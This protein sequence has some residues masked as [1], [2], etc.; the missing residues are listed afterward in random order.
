MWMADLSKTA[1][2]AALI[3]HAQDISSLTIK[4][5]FARES[6]R[7]DWG[8]IDAA[9][10]RFD[11]T[12]QSLGRSTRDLLVD[13]AKAAD[14]EGRRSQMLAGEALNS[15]ENRPAL[16]MALRADKDA[17]HE[18]KS[19]RK[20]LL[21]FVKDI[22]QGRVL[23]SAG[24]PFKT[25][26]NIGIGGS[27]LGPR[28]A[29]AALHPYWHKGITPRFVANVDGTE[30]TQVL[31]EVVPQE[32]LFIVASKSFGTQETLHNAR[33]AMKWLERELPEG[34]DIG[35]HF[36]GVT[37]NADAAEGFGIS[38]DRIFPIWDWVGGR[39]SVWSSVG[40]SLAL[41][42]GADHFKEFLSGAAQMDHHFCTA[43][44]EQNMPIL[45]GLV[46]V[47]NRNFLGNSSHAI[48]PY[49]QSLALLPSYLQQL[50]MESNGK[51][52]KRDGAPVDCSTAPAI[53]GAAGT[54]G[55]H[56][57]YQ[58]LHQ[59]TD[60]ASCDILLPLRPHHALR[61]H[62]DILVSHAIAQADGL[63]FGRDEAATRAE[64]ASE[65]LSEGEIAAMAPHR[66]FPGNRP[67]SILTM[68]RLTPATLGAMLALYEHKVFTQG[69][70]WN[71]NSF[72]QWGV[73]LGKS[74]AGTV[75]DALLGD[76][77]PEGVNP[78][79]QKL[80]EAARAARSS[81][82]SES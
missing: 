20:R 78:S 48:L 69:V 75:L 45:L 44:L 49:D 70:L 4:D 43:P 62:H 47:W 46:G 65:G 55:Q 21:A 73:E 26:V 1:E 63:A 22:H 79:T 67:V 54:T 14:V 25:I 68:E 6:D 15:S 30:I 72:D 80:I 31:S 10:I 38:Q 41:A 9:G 24:K 33:T 3:A 66:T 58:W 53:W 27:D 60:Q 29:A 16:H 40:L 7:V 36:V 59:G 61:D 28:L 71:I 5:H 56:A 12:R 42:I 35:A 77:M 51:S 13:F 57:F 50:E 76:D 39:F 32:T 2:W 37:A 74:L 17:S 52:V 18:V 11:F 82:E 81:G 64:L 23:S 34:A 8:V 19:S